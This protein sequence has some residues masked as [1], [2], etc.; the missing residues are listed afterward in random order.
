M[1]SNEPPTTRRLRALA[2]E[3][4]IQFL[5][6]GVLLFA[7]QTAVDAN[8]D[9]SPTESSAIVIT[10]AQIDAAARDRESRS[11]QPLSKE[12][13]EAVA[14]TLVREEIYFREAMSL[15][16]DR[17][18]SIIRRRLVQKMR[19]L[20]ED[21]F[22]SAVP[23][24]AE[25]RAFIAK[26]PRRYMRPHRV[27]FDHVFFSRARRDDPAG[28]ASDFLAEIGLAGAG[29]PRGGDPFV[30]GNAIRSA[31]EKSVIRMFGQGFADALFREAEGASSDPIASTFGTHLVFIRAL[32]REGERPLEQVREA[33]TRD[34]QRARA[35]SFREGAFSALRDRYTVEIEGQPAGHE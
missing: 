35:A 10:A 26:A 22:A 4:L 3:P 19:F 25:L 27:T 20:T 17:S 18:D 9:E 31:S 21:R 16:L 13:R 12:E 24:D 23:S 1:F 15:G 11:N 32:E 8:D 28:D 14:E 7:A 5:V 30:H 33:A 34:W 6:I 29:S 2:R